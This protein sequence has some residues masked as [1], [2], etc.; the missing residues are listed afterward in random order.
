MP[1]RF[2]ERGGRNEAAMCGPISIVDSGCRLRVDGQ[3]EAEDGAMPVRFFFGEISV[4]SDCPKKF[5]LL[6]LLDSRARL[7][8]ISEIL[9][10]LIRAL[11]R[12]RGLYIGSKI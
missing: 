1:A 5:A 10:I 8:D 9:E 12:A 4:D 6:L 11:T 7:F 3:S 2:V